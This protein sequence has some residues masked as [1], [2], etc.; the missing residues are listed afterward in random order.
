[1]KKGF[2]IAGGA[3]VLAVIVIASLLRG[4]DEGA[5]VYVHEVERRDIARI[6]KDRKSVV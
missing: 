6:V 3:L 2:L 1:M 5:E 4:G